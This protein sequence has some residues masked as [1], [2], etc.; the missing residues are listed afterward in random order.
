MG[1]SMSGEA[2]LIEK[3][4]NDLVER[5]YRLEFHP[6]SAEKLAREI[7]DGLRGFDANLTVIEDLGLPLIIVRLEEY[8]VY[9]PVLGEKVFVHLALSHRLMH[10]MEGLLEVVRRSELQPVLLVYSFRGVLSWSSNH[11]LGKLIDNRKYKILFKNGRV[12]EIMEIVWSI[13]EVGKYIPSE[14][15]VMEL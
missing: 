1:V 14:E 11:Y 6:E 2:G 7:L 15:D 8:I 5:G 4:V 13:K 12:E 9:I 10:S 3:F